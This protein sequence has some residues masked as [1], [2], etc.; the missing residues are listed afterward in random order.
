M[1]NVYANQWAFSWPSRAKYTRNT[2]AAA[3][4]A[5]LPAAPA[6]MV[7]ETAASAAF[8][9][10]WASICALCGAGTTC[11]RSWKIHSAPASM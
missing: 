1:K 3:A 10:R 8:R 6:I 4:P 5:R 7:I 11:N 9:N 2:T